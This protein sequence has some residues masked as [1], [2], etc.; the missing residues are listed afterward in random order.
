VGSITTTITNLPPKQNHVGCTRRRSGPA[1]WSA[2]LQ[3]RE[4]ESG[5]VGTRDQTVV[6]W[7]SCHPRP[8]SLDRSP[9][10]PFTQLTALFISHRHITQPIYL[11]LCVAGCC[12]MSPS[13]SRPVCVCVLSGGAFHGINI[14]ISALA[15]RGRFL[16]LIRIKTAFK[17]CNLCLR[18]KEE[19]GSL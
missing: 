6:F 1:I 11:A 5:R 4:R 7:P 13:L 2:N 19:V 18:L 16:R 15:F 14:A 12:E 8:S 17:I 10:T 9:D 3:R